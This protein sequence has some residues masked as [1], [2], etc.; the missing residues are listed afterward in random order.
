MALNGHADRTEYVS[1]LCYGRV[2]DG[3]CSAPYSKHDALAY[4]A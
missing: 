1:S 4:E 2:A 3:L